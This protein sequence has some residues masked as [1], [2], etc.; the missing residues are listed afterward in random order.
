MN[1]GEYYRAEVGK[2][3]LQSMRKYRDTRNNKVS[4]KCYPVQCRQKT[5]TITFSPPK[6]PSFMQQYANISIMIFR[7]PEGLVFTWTNYGPLHIRY[8][9]LELWME[10]YGVQTKASCKIDNK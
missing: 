9:S 10:A 8:F 2:E 4:R 7:Q 6:L 3:T 1:I 5:D